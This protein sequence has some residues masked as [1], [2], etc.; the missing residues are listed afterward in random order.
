MFLSALKLVLTPLMIAL[1][2]MA[3]RRWGPVVG[4]LLVGLPLTSGPVSVFL[5]L[6]QGRQFAAEAGHS[7][8]LGVLAV[9]AFCVAYARAARVLSWP[10]AF[11]L[12]LTAYA[13]MVTLLSTLVLPLS[14]ST[15][16]TVLLTAT[17]LR[18]VGPVEACAPPPASPRWDLPFRMV[19]AT[20]I[21][22]AITSLSTRL[23]PQ[24][25]G[26]LSGFP[27]FV[28]V[29]SVFSHRLHGQAAV[30][31]LE[32][33]VVLASFAFIAF[34]LVVS[35]TIETLALPLVYTLACLAAIVV[36]LAAY[37]LCVQERSMH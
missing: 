26:L 1:P 31:Q 3:A 20:A 25:S 9:I 32:R 19:A 37:K 34:Y 6:E 27:V 18:A 4:G 36:N 29:M 17:A 28:C 12:A 35:L 2:T 13:L 23:G 30:R 11:L 7:T 22:F 8:M 24:L 33:G 14:A 5:A 16:L 21:V 10:W 15:G